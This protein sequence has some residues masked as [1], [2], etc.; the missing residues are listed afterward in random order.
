MLLEDESVPVHDGPTRHPLVVFGDHRFCAGE[1]LDVRRMS[2]PHMHSQVELNYVLD[3]RIT[4][5]F[6]GRRLQISAGQLCLFWGMIPHQ[7]VEVTEPTNFVCLYV[8]MSV[9]VNFNS[10][11]SFRDAVFRGGL[12]EALNP[13][14]PD[15]DVFLR[16]R[17]ELLSGDPELEQIV[18]DELVARIRRIARDGWQDLRER[19][20]AIEISRNQDPDRLPRIEKMLRF[21]AEKALGEISA[22]DVGLAA[23]LHPNYAMSIF[24]KAVGLTIN[25]AITRHR[26]DTAQ[27]LLISSDLPVAAVAFE[28]GFGSLSRFYEAFEGR[29]ST[30]P[31]KYRSSFGVAAARPT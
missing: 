12:I 3:G 17:E 6:D 7:V 13:R 28:A 14:P 22:I 9:L 31:A 18:R 1:R 5:W 10:M 25:Q 24:K 20:S 21:I 15:R 26:L 2:G 23:G 29:F 4:Y 11:S 16:W 30:T 27:S 8:P 19:S